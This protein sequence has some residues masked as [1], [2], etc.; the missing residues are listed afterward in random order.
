MEETIDGRLYWSAATTAPAP[1]P[2]KRRSSP[3]YLLPNYDEYLIAY[4]DRPAANSTR[5]ANM[6]A[7][8]NGAFPHH[9]VIA[10]RLA[11]SWRRTVKANSVAVE[12]APYKALSKAHTRAVTG[13]AECYSEFLNMPLEFTIY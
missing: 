12:V 10:G 9:L 7:R 11:G 6:E 8:S 5:A 2:A 4:K 1:A 13:E 3:V